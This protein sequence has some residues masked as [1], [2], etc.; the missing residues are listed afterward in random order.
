MNNP[1]V[2]DCQIKQTTP[3]LSD[4]QLLTFV[5]NHYDLEGI[6]EKLPGY[7]D[8]N[9]KLLTATGQAYVI[10]VANS[11]RHQSELTFENQLMQQLEKYAALSIDIPQLMPVLQIPAKQ[12][13]LPENDYPLVMLEIKDNNGNRC[14]LRVINFI[15]G[16]LWAESK[17]DNVHFYQS[18][19]QVLGHIDKALVNYSHPC[20]HRYFEWNM[21]YANCVMRANEQYLRDLHGRELVT[22]VIALFESQVLPFSDILPKQVI[23]NDA[24]DYNLLVNSDQ[25]CLSG[26][27]DFGDA[28]FS[29]RI[30]ELAIACAYAVLAPSDI[31][32]HHQVNNKTNTNT[33][34]NTIIRAITLS[35]HQ[36]NPLKSE[37]IDV[38][39]PLICARLATSVCLSSREFAKDPENDYLLISQK[40]AWQ[41][42]STLMQ[43]DQTSIILSLK[44]DC[45]FASK[46][47]QQ[48]INERQTL[49]SENLSLAYRTP[50]KIVR[51]KSVYLYSESGERYLD[52][53]N[54]V[55]HVGHCHPHVVSAGQKQMTLLNTNTRYLHDN[56]IQ[57]AKKLTATM[58]AKLS[59]C[60]FVNSGSEANEL[61]IRL[62][63]AHTQRKAMV[64]VEGAYHGNSNAC[65]DIS[66]YKF[67]GPGGNGAPDWVKQTI[68]P[69]P[70]YGRYQGSDEKIGE[71]YALDVQ[72]VVNE[73]AAENNPVAAFICESIQGVGGQIVHPQGYLQQVYRIIRQAGGVCIADEVQVGM[74]RVGT[75][76]WAFQTQAVIPD[77]VTIGKPIGNGHPLAAVVTTSEIARSFVSGMEYFNTFGG[78]PV[79]C[80]IGLAVMEVIE[81][82]KLMAN[83]LSVGDYLKQGLKAL[84]EKFSIIGDVRGT[85]L[86]IG[87]EFVIDRK[88]KAPA[89]EQL[90]YVIEEMK[91]CGILLSTEGPRHNVLKIKPPMVFSRDDAEHFLLTLAEVL[92]KL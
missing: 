49:L 38:L 15:E 88:T 56:I 11:Q 87:A 41:A 75:H 62:A 58:P 4:D 55:C 57:F 44:F 85:G 80:A 27:I 89:A 92:S 74:G 73:F 72:R 83:A 60:M 42:L 26:L 19:G 64:V 13:Q 9:R 76:W 82:E 39:L 66:P 32:L 46:N 33:K 31:V 54:N 69:D 90:A 8:Y 18:L 30:A 52:M 35:Y 71:Q 84:G 65:I 25:K 24:N 48:L 16:Q 68:V 21:Q 20:A 10:K 67:D 3:Q 29:W 91:A 45:G 77:I 81:N 28:C 70:Y 86:F 36:I 50:L 61:A 53:V 17:I 59:V 51:G 40:G 6:L 2:N 23:Y 12:T 79:S 78:N 1:A 7:A 63:R 47:E 22:R 37:E 43:L 34:F 5:K 14:W